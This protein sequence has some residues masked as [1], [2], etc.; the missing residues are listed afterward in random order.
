MND[1]PDDTP[2]DSAAP[3]NVDARL[4]RSLGARGGAPELSPDLITGAQAR[5]APHLVNRHRRIQAAGGAT[6]AIA[7]VTVGALVVSLPTQRAPLFLAARS[8]SSNSSSAAA[9]AESSTLKR[10][11]GAAT[12]DLRIAQWIDYRYE[13]G[14]SLSSEAGTGSVY[15]LKRA[16]TAESRLRAVAGA[17]GVTGEP[18]KASYS[19]PAYPTW[20]V[21]PEDGTAASVTITW[22]GTGDWW[23]NDPTAMPQVACAELPTT[24]ATGGPAIDVLPACE[25]PPAT[26]EAS[27][28]PSE[29]EARAEARTL[30]GKTGLDV[31]ADDIRVTTDP[32][33]TTATTNLTV[34]G[35]QT[36]LEWTVAWSPTGRIAW[37]SGHSIEVVDRGSYGTISAAAAVARLSD[38]RWFGAAGPEFQGGMRLLADDMLRSADAPESPTAG[39]EP[40]PQAIDPRDDP[41]IEPGPGKTEPPSVDPGAEPAPAPAPTTPPTD[42]AIPPTAEPQPEP[43]AE[44][45]PVPEKPQVVVVT[46]DKA[47]PTLLMMWD[48][49]G[50][51][52]LVPGFAMQHPDGWWNTIVSLDDGVIQL[53][54]PIETPPVDDNVMREKG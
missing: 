13:A 33:Q 15:Q 34:D 21:G 11:A 26:A 46:V 30:F 29:S 19:D 20:M 35:T 31:S 22:A 38:Y 48:A 44:P 42:P 10:S 43:S 28:A 32:G 14:A 1:F 53:P 24:D 39:T 49:E 2:G 36:A 54:A 40:A 27:L 3:G 16:G 47:T 51:A 9:G 37:A 6:L 23:Y 52:W 41:I 8:G 17:L 18:A 5:R 12:D 4:R 45:S 50:G 25:V 7:A